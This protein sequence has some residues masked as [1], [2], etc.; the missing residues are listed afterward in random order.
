MKVVV[1]RKWLRRGFKKGREEA[2]KK[3]FLF[4]FRARK[5]KK[6]VIKVGLD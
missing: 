4:F 2:L 5:K 1:V 6:T 3:T